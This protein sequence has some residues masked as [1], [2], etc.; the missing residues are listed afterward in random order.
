[1]PCLPGFTFVNVPQVLR[2]HPKA[3]SQ[4][5]PQENGW[6]SCDQGHRGNWQNSTKGRLIDRLE[7][8]KRFRAGCL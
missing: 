8:I 1:M 5:H 7:M 6:L 2:R 4:K 3:S